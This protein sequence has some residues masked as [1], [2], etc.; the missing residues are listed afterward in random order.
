MG[1]KTITIINNLHNSYLNGKYS[2]LYDLLCEIERMSVF[3]VN[4][5][6]N[7]DV[8]NAIKSNNFFIENLFDN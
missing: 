6:L 7:N 1:N 4:N 3:M 8:L 5:N 2:G